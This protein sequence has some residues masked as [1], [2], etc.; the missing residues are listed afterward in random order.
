M[1]VTTTEVVV[2]RRS[3]PLYRPKS[4]PLSHNHEHI[5]IWLM[6]K[7]VAL[8][9]LLYSESCFFPTTLNTVLP[10]LYEIGPIP[11]ALPPSG[12]KKH[13]KAF[14][15]KCTWSEILLPFCFRVLCFFISPL[16]H[17]RSS[18]SFAWRGS[19]FFSGLKMCLWRHSCVRSEDHTTKHGGERKEPG[20]KI[21]VA[22][23][24][25]QSSWQ[26]AHC[27]NEWRA[28]LLTR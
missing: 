4:D 11:L 26:N 13:R 16:L 14:Y 19:I 1:I 17:F 12:K 2:R 21:L 28:Q 3:A 10:R 18:S 9:P 25:I 6:Q 8:I 5:L 23:S 15:L 7:T 22:F 20:A 24:H 27:K